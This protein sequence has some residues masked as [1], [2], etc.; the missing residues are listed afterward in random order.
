LQGEHSCRW[1]K[2]AENGTESA[3]LFETTAMSI[4]KASIAMV[5][6]NRCNEKVGGKRPGADAAGAASKKLKT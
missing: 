6:S 2:A 3:I 1:L 4:G 5:C